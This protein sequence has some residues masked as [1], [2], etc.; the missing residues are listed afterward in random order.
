MNTSTNSNQNLYTTTGAARF[1]FVR[2]N[3]AGALL[4][5]AF[6]STGIGL[7]ATSYADDGAP[8]PNLADAV[9]AGPTCRTE[10]FGFLGSQRRTLCDGPIS[11]DGSWSRE[12]TIWAPAHYSTPICTSYGSDRSYSS[13]N[14]SGG[15]FVNER[16]ITN[17]TYPV[18]P[19]TVLPDEP[20][21][22]G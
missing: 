11:S 21:H 8:A 14:C 19:E 9:H 3:I 22:L 15:Y 17:E 12:R 20:G 18:R 10:P 2:R 4:A 13:Y 6:S 1:G 16:L 5:M 7:A